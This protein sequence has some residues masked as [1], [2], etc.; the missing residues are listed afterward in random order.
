M[1]G[2][3][4]PHLGEAPRLE[5]WSDWLN[6]LLV[7]EVRQALRGRVFS[8][9]IVLTAL[10]SAAIL[11]CGIL[12]MGTHRPDATAGLKIYAILYYL[13]W[14]LCCVLLPVSAASRFRNERSSGE[15]ELFLI[16]GISARQVVSG[17]LQAALVQVLLAL[18]TAAPFLMACHV[19]RGISALHIALSLLCLALFTVVLAQGGI[20]LGALTTSKVM[21]GLFMVPFLWLLFATFTLPGALLM[22]DGIP[23][24]FGTSEAYLGL[25]AALAALLHYFLLFHFGAVAMLEPESR[26]RTFP[27]RL[28]LL[29]AAMVLPALLLFVSDLDDQDWLFYLLFL[30]PAV[31]ATLLT[32]IPAQPV[33][34][35]IRLRWGKGWRRWLQPLFHPDR[36]SVLVWL[37]LFLGILTAWETALDDDYVVSSL[38]AVLLFWATLGNLLGRLIAPRAPTLLLSIIGNGVP[39]ILSTFLYFA[40]EEEAAQMLLPITTGEAVCDLGLDWALP[41]ALAAIWAMTLA[42]GLWRHARENAKPA[43]GG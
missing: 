33:A 34:A 17:K 42:Y 41:F 28:F 23:E 18:A 38:C 6:P 16:T 35:P 20:L 4:T 22:G 31:A 5:R 27:L 26:N 7:R 12:A 39:A 24:L 13:L 37:A 29:G 21:F 3:E 19:L 43:S 25:L 15:F 10:V 2:R 32:P 14:S 11:V 8:G 1:N 40:D 36:G 9:V 30:P